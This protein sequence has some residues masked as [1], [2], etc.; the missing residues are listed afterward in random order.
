MFLFQD[1]QR[2]N[3]VLTLSSFPPGIAQHRLPAP[4]IILSPL[5]RRPAPSWWRG[6]EGAVF[7]VQAAAGT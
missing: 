7:V 3:D 4:A 5:L 6:L 1:M 2:S